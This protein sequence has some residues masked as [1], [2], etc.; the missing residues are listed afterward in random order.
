MKRKERMSIYNTQRW[1]DLRAFKMLNNPL[2][3]E[4]EKADKVTPVDDVHHIV[5]FMSTDDLVYRTQLAFDYEN[6]MSVCDEC[7]QKLHNKKK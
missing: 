2:C 7:H 6:L 5:S 1:R 4:C 3:E